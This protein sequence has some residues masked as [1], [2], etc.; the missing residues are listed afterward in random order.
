VDFDELQRAVFAA[1]REA[2]TAYERALG[3]L[4]D[5]EARLAREHEGR[6]VFWR[7]CF[8]SLTGRPAD[9]LAVLEDGLERGVWWDPQLLDRDPDLT[10]MRQLDG[11]ERLRERLLDHQQQVAT[12]TSPRLL[13][14]LPARAVAEPPCPV[15]LVL[16][17]AWSSAARTRPFWDAALEAG[18]ALALAQSSQ[19]VGTDAF[20]WTDHDRALTELGDHI[21]T[22]QARGDVDVHRGVLGGFSQGAALALS[23]VLTDR[24][25]LTRFIAQAPSF[26][27]IQVD[28]NVVDHHP[29]RQQL[30]GIVLVGTADHAYDDATTMAA[31]LDSRIG[32]CDLEVVDGLGHDAPPDLPDRLHRWLAT[33]HPGR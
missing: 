26:G 14:E 11:Y 32:R 22:L 16:H 12:E 1:H 29:R 31:T 19:P 28:P 3:L 27:S 23:A 6:L 18:W 5:A 10:A 21:D 9:A 33:W 13:V 17:G 15:L 2:V 7:A 24:V 4:D 30:E 8:T 25:P 20:V